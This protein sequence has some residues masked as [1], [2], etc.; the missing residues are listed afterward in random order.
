MRRC[1]IECSEGLLA[2]TFFPLEGETVVGRS[3]VCAIRL[4]G[5]GI[6]RKHA[7]LLFDGERWVLTDL[8]SQNGTFVNGRRVQVH[9]LQDGDLIQVGQVNLK[10]LDVEEPEVSASLSETQVVSVPDLPE[11][12][13]EQM[14]LV[15]TFLDALP[16]GVSIINHKMEVRH[17]NRASATLHQTG[18]PKEGQPLGLFLSCRVLAGGGVGCGQAESCRRCPLF[19]ASKRVFSARMATLGREISWAQD[20]N[21]APHY[22]R[23]S[24]TP[25]PYSLTGESLAQVSWED[26]TAR[27]AAQTAL[28]EA[29]DRLERHVQERTEGLLRANEHLRAEMEDRR[30]AE[31]EKRIL[32]GQLLQAQKMEAIGTMAG[33]IAH[34]FNNILAAI[35]GYAELARLEMPEDNGAMRSLDELLQ[36][37]NRAKSLIAQIL[38]F[39]RKTRQELRPIVVAPIIKEALKLLRASIPSTIEIRHTMD[40]NDVVIESDPTQ[41]HQVLMNLCTNAAHAMMDRGG[42]LEVR[43]TE[44]FVAEEDSPLQTAGVRP[45]R[46]LRLTVQDTGHGMTPEVTKRAFEPYFTT[47]EKGVG[48]GMGLAV[49]H[50]I[51]KNHG[52]AIRLNSSPGQGT[53]VEVDFP[54]TEGQVESEAKNHGQLLRGRERILFV[55]DDPSL[56]D[57]AS[58]TLTQLGYAVCTATNGREALEVFL[59]HSHEFDLV[60]TDMTMPVM[61]GDRLAEALME[62]KPGLPVVLCT[63]FSESISE[64]RAKALGIREFVLKPLSMAGTAELVRRTLDER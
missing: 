14:D 49:V 24:I 61:T 28:Q 30:R 36:A 55:D 26:V 10:Y 23:F 32:E 46:F 50:G 11:D 60:I 54:I 43:L 42:V 39:S 59:R 44:T 45:G 22:I 33:G 4:S 40:A 13:R 27:V 8:S 57:I 34:D 16:I 29:N 56:V 63:G 2:R 12:I 25:L 3:P 21:Q 48:T 41:I 52:G 19:D 47:K 15:R 9:S 38:A 6:S 17:F 18:L 20:G 58:R 53:A 31:D 7:S 37:S 64:E 1:M 5:T 62:M 51:V 35:M